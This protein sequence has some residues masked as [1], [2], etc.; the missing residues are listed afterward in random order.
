M[1][2]GD[3]R[4]FEQVPLPRLDFS[5]QFAL[6]PNGRRISRV[7]LLKV[8]LQDLEQLRVRDVVEGVDELVVNLNI[9]KTCLIRHNNL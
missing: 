4:Q 7:L 8:Q 5:L 6:R 9:K 3:I 1:L 2:L